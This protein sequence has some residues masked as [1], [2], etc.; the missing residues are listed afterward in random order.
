MPPDAPSRLAGR[1]R[2]VQW[3]ALLASSAGLIA[4]FD[5]LGMPAAVLLGA[6]GGGMLA[7]GNGACVRMPQWSFVA[8]QGVIGCMIANSM[9]PDILAELWADWPLCVAAVLSV[10][11]ASCLLGWV[12]A[13]RQVLPG[14]TAVWGL[15]PGAA[16]AMILMSEAYG[17]DVR[18]VAFMQYLRVVL[19]VLAA[20]AVSRIWGISP[21]A[22]V[23]AAATPGWLAPVAAGPFAA[24]LAVA[25][26]G[27][28]AARRLRLPAGSLLLPLAVGVAL[29][30]SGVLALTLPPWLLGLSYAVIGWSIGLRFDRA[31]LLHALRALPRVMLAVLALMAICGLLAVALAELGGVDPLTA[32][33]ATSPGGA[34]SVA[35]I[36]ASSPVDLPFVMTLQTARFILVILL[37]PALARVVAQ[38]SGRMGQVPRP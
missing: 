12:L 32:Y 13:R 15:S 16:T 38:Y 21:Q 29:Q 28:W 10:I 34:D 27:A 24:T 37:G 19:V 36:A 5:L 33:L 8:A 9:Q 17:A 22:A 14:T 2:G 26:L 18:L 7:A 30:N 25:L 1:N 6:V 35:I 20:S 4:L 11:I 23:H 3:G 31:V